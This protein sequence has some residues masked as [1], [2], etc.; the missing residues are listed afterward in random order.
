MS[1]GKVEPPPGTF[2]NTSGGGPPKKGGKDEKKNQ[3]GGG[4]GGSGGG[5]GGKK[6]YNT[7]PPGAYCRTKG[8]SRHGW[9]Q[10]A[11]P[12]EKCPECKWMMHD[13]R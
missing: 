2:I 3:A 10:H 8:C 11:T 12:G 4:G 9:A 1:T 5:G 13:H 6:K 7:L